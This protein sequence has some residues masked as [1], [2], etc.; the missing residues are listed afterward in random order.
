MQA[1]LV[2]LWK[3]NLNDTLKWTKLYISVQ[4]ECINELFF[5]RELKHDI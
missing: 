1:I 4:L 3:N 5:N 2:Y